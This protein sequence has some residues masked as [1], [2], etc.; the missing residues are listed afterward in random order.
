[1]TTHEGFIDGLEEGLQPG[2][3]EMEK[4]IDEFNRIIDEATTNEK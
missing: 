4:N 3:E 1:M 2:L